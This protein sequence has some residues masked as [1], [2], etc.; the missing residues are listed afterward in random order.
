MPLSNTDQFFVLDPGN[1]PA[2]GTAL[3]PCYLEVT[4]RNNGGFLDGFSNDSI[5]G[6][7]IAATWPG[8]TVTV[9]M[10]G[11]RITISGYSL[12]L[13][14]GSAV[15]TPS[16]GTVLSAATFKSSTY[17]TSQGLMP[18][19]SLGPPCFVLGTT[20]LTSI[21]SRKIEDLSAGDL[22]ETVDKGL[23]PIRWV[24]GS[25]TAGNGEYAPVLF[26]E[27]A[28]GNVADLR[29]SPQHR[30]LINDHRAQQLFGRDEVLVPAKHLVDGMSVVREQANTVEYFH[31]LFDEHELIFS[32]GAVT[33][34]FFPGEDVLHDRQA[35]AEL[36]DLIPEFHE[37][38]DANVS[39]STQV[40][41]KGRE[42]RVMQVA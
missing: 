6:K 24:G 26:R 22:V 7:N 16:D 8:D 18:A 13:A 4:D 14:D 11:E 42:A 23:C 35:R 3:T 20:I 19:P 10:G 2:V 30:V 29:V 5:D 1:P 31:I 25:R 37:D 17:V 27:G 28:I 32:D 34:T 9:V 21:G 41:H 33:E 15:F 40:S 12:Y 36:V 39:R 38:G